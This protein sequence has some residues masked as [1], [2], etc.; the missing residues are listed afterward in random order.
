[1]SSL[2]KYECH[3]WVNQIS[4]PYLR[5]REIATVF[6]AETSKVKILKKIMRNRE[7]CFAKLL[8][9]IFVDKFGKVTQFPDKW[10]RNFFKE[11]VVCLSKVKGYFPMK[12]NKL[13]YV[14]FWTQDW[15]RKVFRKKHFWVYCQKCEEQQLELSL[16]GNRYSSFQ[17]K[18]VVKVIADE[19]V[20]KLRIWSRE[21]ISFPEQ[22]QTNG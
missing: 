17:R 1:M 4:T 7:I 22:I 9:L 15:C 20:G 10:K 5:C 14:F 19:I 12:S 16:N 11:N 18:N 21:R 8:K 3:Q 13:Y 6:D 2:D